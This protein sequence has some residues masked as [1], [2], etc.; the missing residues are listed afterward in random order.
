MPLSDDKRAELLM[1]HYKDTFE[2]ILYHWKARNRLF[3]IVLVVLAFMA[4][5]GMS[6]GQL[7]KIVNWYVDKAVSPPQ[8]QASALDLGVIGSA[9][10]F[11]LLTLIIQYYQRSIHVDRQYRY[12]QALED[13]FQRSG[14]D[15]LAREGLSYLSRTGEAEGVG[16]QRP[17]YLRAVGGIYV[18]AFPALLT[19]LVV[20]KLAVELRTASPAHPGPLVFDFLIGIVLT[21]Y[22]LAYVHWVLAR[23]KRVTAPVPNVGRPATAAKEREERNVAPVDHGA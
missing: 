11:L 2:V 9:F 17:L 10:W 20:W 15:F 8:G 5:D 4:V 7:G 18:Y 21:A 19:V 12:I 22:N 6:P 14:G 23:K 3:V 1:A 13:Q 16:D